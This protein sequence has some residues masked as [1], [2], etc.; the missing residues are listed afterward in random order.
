MRTIF[1]VLAMS[2]ALNAGAAP[3]AVPI[4]GE[5]VV[6]DTIP[7]FTD[8]LPSG[9]P[10][11]L[12]LAESLASASNRI[13]LFALT[14]GDLRRFTL[15][16]RADLKRYMLVVTPGHL[17]RE[18]VSTA[19]F[20][21]LVE[22]AQRDAGKPGDIAD[23]RKYLEERPVGQISAL[24]QLRQGADAY[25]VLLGARVTAGGWLAKAEYLLSTS[26]LL[27]VRGKAL[28]MSIYTS[29]DSPADLDWIRFATERW[30]DTLQKLNA[31]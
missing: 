3:Y 19:Q 17:E 22:D 12:E 21:A 7:G 10:R 23:F 1:A 8:A 26:T 9:S 25:S 5:R 16:D 27:L 29:F 2:A 4:G 13:L 18:R 20:K 28:N 6:L 15:G 31:R 11:L 14:D 24:A 30:I